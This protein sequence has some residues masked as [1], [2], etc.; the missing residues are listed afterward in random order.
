MLSHNKK[1]FYPF[2]ISAGVVVGILLGSFLANHFSG[3]RLSIINNSSNKVIDLFHLVE[4]QYVDSVEIPQLVEKALPQI[5][6]ELDPHSTYVS[7]A[8][9]E[10]SMQD[11]KGRFSG[12]G[13]QFL[14]YR[15]TVC[16]VKVIKGGPSESA[17]LCAG[18]RI[19]SINGE[20]YTGDTISNTGVAK[21]LKGA[22]NSELDV[23]V[24]RPGT[25]SLLSFHIT[26]GDIPLKTIDAVY[27]VTPKIGYI[28]IKNFGDTTYSEFL[29][30]L[31]KLQSERFEGL[32]LDLRGNPGGYME[33]AVQIANDFLPKNSLIVYT[34]GRKSARKDYYT[35]GRGTF[36]QMPLVILID[37]TSASAS[38]ILAGAIQDN[39]RGTIMGRRS[40][41]KGLVQVPIEFTDG[42]MLRLTIARYYT[43]SGRCVQKPYNDGA[44]DYEADLLERAEHGEYFSADSIHTSGLAYKTR[45]GRTVYGGGGII[46]DV[47]VPRDSTGITEY[48]KNVYF[49]GLI[50]QYAYYFVDKNRSKLSEYGTLEDV[51]D[52]L[53]HKNLVDDFANYASREGV[54]RRN[55]MIRRSAQL[56]KAHITT[57]IISDVL[58]DDA[59]IQ[60]V[61]ATDKAVLNAV[62]VLESKRAFPVS[63][64]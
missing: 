37:E 55:L 8:D 22:K 14:I 18:D 53:S 38:E 56:L 20:S 44:T 48:F 50:G 13:V 27:M 51:T 54:K 36:P 24:K 49:S 34:E 21:R 11:L 59:P 60:Y 47:F 2:F 19:V 63:K 33:T 45:L 28:R 23:M 10:E 40:F 39:D 25:E 17:G 62:E 32:I 46:P 58:D 26:R 43:P 31:A 42:S 5:L 9:V 4:D 30:A 15:D 41:G 52:F 1:R 64:K 12:I 6:K 3:N 7:A 16:V 29:A 57:A 35:D 61:N